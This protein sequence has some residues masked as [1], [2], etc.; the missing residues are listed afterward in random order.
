MQ[1]F[2]TISAMKI[3]AANNDPIIAMQTTINYR[4]VSEVS[5]STVFAVFC[6]ALLERIAI[7][8]TPNAVS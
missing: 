4:Q 8:D 3:T 7:I 1:V 2:L 5:M 6:S